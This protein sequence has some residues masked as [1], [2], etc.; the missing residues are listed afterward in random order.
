MSLLSRDVLTVER[1]RR[2]IGHLSLTTSILCIIKRFAG[3]GVFRPHCIWDVTQE[4]DENDD[5][6]DDD[7]NTAPSSSS[8]SSS[9]SASGYS[10]WS[11]SFYRRW[12]WMSLRVGRFTR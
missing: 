5:D 1:R 2:P 4:Y 12:S 7:N 10:C 9:T 6:V 3:D 8:S 11:C